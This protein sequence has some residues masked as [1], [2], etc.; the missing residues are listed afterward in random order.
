MQRMT[1]L[2]PNHSDAEAMRKGLEMIARSMNGPGL[3]AKTGP[4]GT[5]VMKI[6]DS[7]GQQHQLTLD[8]MG[9]VTPDSTHLQQFQNMLKIRYNG[10]P[11]HE[12]V[13]PVAPELQA[14]YSRIVGDLNRGDLSSLQDAMKNLKNLNPQ[15]A[16]KMKHMLDRVAAQ[17]TSPQSEGGFNHNTGNFELEVQD[18]GGNWRKV[19]IGPGG[20]I[21]SDMDRASFL[22]LLQE[23]ANRRVHTG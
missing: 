12:R 6:T 13:T 21:N 15:D 11:E 8:N 1:V 10:D 5:F 7:N 16:A 17:F 19:T 23:R 4:D 2:G 9:R 20:E 22:K 18:E 14:Q 3:E